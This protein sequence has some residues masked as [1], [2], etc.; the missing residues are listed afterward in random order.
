MSIAESERAVASGR[1][2]LRMAAFVVILVGIISIGLDST[3]YGYLS[4]IKY[5]AWWAGL[6]VVVV[7]GVTVISDS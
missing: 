1:T 5:G 4:N 2:P 7:G 6:C 3:V